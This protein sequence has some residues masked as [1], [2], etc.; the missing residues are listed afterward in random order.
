MASYS[1]LNDAFC[2]KEYDELDRMARNINNKTHDMY[3]S[4][5]SNCELYGN[6][7]STQKNTDISSAYGK[8]MEKNKEIDPPSTMSTLDM[9]DDF[10]FYSAQGNIENNSS[11]SKNS[12]DFPNFTDQSSI[13]TMESHNKKRNYQKYIDRIQNIIKHSHIDD[14]SYSD[15]SNSYN[16]ILKHIDSCFKCRKAVKNKINK[17][18]GKCNYKNHLNHYIDDD[19]H[20]DYENI[21][22]LD[23][24]NISNV[25]ETSQI[26]EKGEYNTY[27]IIITLLIGIGIIIILDLVY[28]STVFV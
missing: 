10:Q 9:S 15:N 23:K 1:N 24:N 3:S 20:S 2:A 8:P 5:Q 21:I 17:R 7:N 19:S 12:I 13:T 11:H 4:Y 14:N 6:T 25:I 28:K 16:D 22:K 26:T 27:N 18:N